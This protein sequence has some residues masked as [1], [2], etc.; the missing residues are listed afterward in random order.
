MQNNLDCGAHDLTNIDQVTAKCFN[1]NNSLIELTDTS[2]S[3]RDNGVLIAG[4]YKTRCSFKSRC[5]GALG[6]GG[7]SND[8]LL[9]YSDS[10]ITIIGGARTYV[11]ANAASTSALIVGYTDGI[12]SLNKSYDAVF[13]V[14]GLTGFDI[15]YNGYRGETTMK[16]NNKM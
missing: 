12:I 3:S 8:I 11:S 13:H 2:E 6:V 10:S 1:A 14:G 16:M 4:G 15:N 9:N 7:S 5:C